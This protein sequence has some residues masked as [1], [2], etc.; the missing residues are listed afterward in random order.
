MTKHVGRK[1]RWTRKDATNYTS[2][3][4]TVFYERGAWHARLAYHVRAPAGPDGRASTWLPHDRRLGPFKR[5]RNAMVA[6]EQEVTFL[7]N[8]HG[9]GIRFGVSAAAGS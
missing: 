4:G 1:Q 5:P 7:R 9:E 3:S 8:H 2:D 6:L